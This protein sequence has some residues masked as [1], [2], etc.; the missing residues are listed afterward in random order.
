MG[1]RN[2][3]L[4]RADRA[5]GARCGGSW[6]TYTYEA[7]I[8]RINGIKS[9]YGTLVSL[10]KGAVDLASGN[11]FGPLAD[12][13][14]GIV[15]LVAEHQ[16]AIAAARQKASRTDAVFA[17][18]DVGAA[19]ASSAQTSLT[20]QRDQLTAAIGAYGTAEQDIRRARDARR[21]ALLQVG[22]EASGEND[23]ANGDIAA[24]LLLV[25]AI[26][27][28]SAQ[29]RYVRKT[30]AANGLDSA[31]LRAVWR[32]T[33]GNR[34]NNACASELRYVYTFE[35]SAAVDGTIAM[36]S[37]L[38][39]SE[40]RAFRSIIDMTSSADTLAQH[41]LEYWGNYPAAAEGKLQKA[42]GS[43]MEAY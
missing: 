42:L 19:L 32:N 3:G 34:K 8:S 22:A 21:E 30:V 6:S 27:E 23:S 24:R 41:N 29:A 39:P 28:T 4:R 11:W 35:E 5:H 12:A 10:C 37:W 33:Y 7:E 38:H 26:L 16:S 20:G 40:E 14:T 2:D 15:G 13:M 18:M 9:S 1:G 17:G 31:S 36:W 43:G 25:G